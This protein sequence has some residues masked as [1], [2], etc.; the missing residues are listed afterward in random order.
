MKKSIAALIMV[1]LLSTFWQALATASE[2]VWF[3]DV[4]ASAD[5]SSKQATVTGKVA[6]GAGQLVTLKVVE[7]GGQFFLDSVKS[8]DGGVFTFKWNISAEG[9]YEVHIGA[10]NSSTPYKTSF[11]YGL[12]PSPTGAPT[13]TPAPSAGPGLGSGGSGAAA[14]QAPS[15]SPANIVRVTEDK[16]TFNEVLKEATFNLET[17]AEAHIPAALLEKLAQ[18]GTGLN[19]ESEQFTLKLSVQTLRDLLDQVSKAGGGE[20]AVSVNKVAA[21]D[22][23]S[24]LE[25]AKQ[26][27]YAELKPGSD[28]YE[29]EMKL[30]T[31]GGAETAISAFDHPL[32]LL[33]KANGLVA[34]KLAG[35]YY[36]SDAGELE[37]FGSMSAKGWLSGKMSHFSKYTV[38][39]YRKTFTDVPAGNWAYDAVTE[40]AA[41]HIV[42]GISLKEF[43]PARKV[44]RAEFA[45]L[46]VR[47]LG[48]SGGS[49]SFTDVP[50]GKWYADE[51][52]AAYQAGIVQGLGEA[53]F[54]PERTISR[55]EMAAMLVRA[56]SVLQPQA[57]PESAA[58]P[59]FKDQAAI[60]VWARDAAGKAAG[61]GLMKGRGAS[62]FVPQ[63]TATRAEAAQAI[64][65]LLNAG[66]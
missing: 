46:L 16:L 54:K 64:A 8:G 36:I 11:T 3:T 49:A 53:S 26:R 24:L 21:A 13:P 6:S 62:A 60:S 47:A 18:S 51:V 28:L 52:A 30:I 39:E 42:E 56:W 12:A 15:P 35:I 14:S 38:L 10:E 44:T 4:S 1:L 63:G 5:A 29:F 27:N 25:L 37:Y 34:A 65:N 9:K 57:Q 7:P 17:G 33:L 40:M 48:L 59:V 41:K 61:L 23:K 19:L 31:S 50:A 32:T 20:V 22:M 45:A 58:P 66:N 2:T 55:E 43:A